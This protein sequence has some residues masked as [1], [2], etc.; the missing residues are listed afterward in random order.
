MSFSLWEI[1]LRCSTWKCPNIAHC[2][3]TATG[4]RVYYYSL[5]VIARRNPD[6]V[7]N[8][9][10][11]V[12]LPPRAP[13]L[14]HDAWPTLNLVQYY[15]SQESQ[16]PYFSS[17]NTLLVHTNLLLVQQETRDECSSGGFFAF[18]HIKLDPMVDMK[19]IPPIH[20]RG[21]EREEELKDII[22]SQC[23]MKLEHLEDRILSQQVGGMD[24]TEEIADI[25]PL[26]EH[27]IKSEPL[28][29]MES[30]QGCTESLDTVLLAENIKSEQFEEIESLSGD[31]ECVGGKEAVIIS[32]EYH[33]KLEPLEDEIP[34]QQIIDMEERD[35]DEIRLQQYHLKLKPMNNLISMQHVCDPE[36]MKDDIPSQKFVAN[37]EDGISSQEADITEHVKKV[38]Y[39]IPSYSIKIEEQQME[40]R[41]PSQLT[42]TEFLDLSKVTESNQTESTFETD[43][44]QIP[45]QKSYL[46][47]YS[48]KNKNKTKSVV[49]DLKEKPIVS[50]SDAKHAENNEKTA[51]E[52]KDI[53]GIITD[54][55]DMKSTTEE[56]CVNNE[57]ISIASC[58]GTKHAE[59]NE[60]TAEESKEINGKKTD[61]TDMKSTT[62]ETCVNNEEQSI[63]SCSDTKHA[64]N[65]ETTVEE[66]KEIDEIKIETTDIKSSTKE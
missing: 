34:S 43:P 64:E 13:K 36:F 30:H 24:C 26:P 6:R 40:D 47:V 62:E 52:S 32:Q 29:E 17:E 55:T 4:P 63:A 51:E 41:I 37:S 38:G 19:G 27:H 56:T 44:L 35:E 3:K 8:S 57:E 50:N 65:N 21:P 59:N 9:S 53:N 11:Q 39:E 23:H 5:E 48:N 7:A 33:I 66:N 45:W 31:M 22:P 61:T 60:K 42:D 1:L 58:S 49:G 12:K 28:E 15:I 2:M 25:I 54:T 20:L 14:R 18:E 16:D 10:Q 46:I